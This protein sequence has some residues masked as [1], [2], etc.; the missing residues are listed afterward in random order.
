[1][2]KPA[3]ELKLGLQYRSIGLLPVWAQWGEL[4]LLHILRQS[5]WS[6][7][8]L[9]LWCS[10][11]WIANL[12][13]KA[14]MVKSTFVESPFVTSQFHGFNF[15]MQRE[16]EESFLRSIL[17]EQNQCFPIAKHSAYTFKSLAFKHACLIHPIKFTLSCLPRV[18][19]P[20]VLS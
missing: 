10:Q 13:S 9:Q 16:R 7:H 11:V 14:P 19:T 18:F 3:L 8:G 17:I 4:F 20:V 1:M 5:C 15:R 12:A 2:S 6:P